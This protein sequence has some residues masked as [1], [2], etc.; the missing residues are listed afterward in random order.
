[1]KLELALD[2]FTPQSAC[3][4][5]ERLQDFIDIVE[6]GTPMLLN[7]GM[8]AVRDMKKAVPGLTLFAD[9]KII[10]GAR[11]E[12]CAAFDAGADIISVVACA[13]DQTIADAVSEA[14]RRGKKVLVDFI[15]VKDLAARAAEISGLGADIF[16]VHMGVDVQKMGQSH[17]PSEILQI[18]QAV[19][20]PEIAV[21]GGISIHNLYA[22]LE[23]GPDI[24][25]VGGGI[26]GQLDPAASA[27]QIR[28]VLD[29]T[30]DRGKNR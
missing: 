24:V 18:K 10:D 30:M 1:M 25:I 15:A 8:A 7:Y 21:A 5:A 19:N 14:S 13:Q 20:G 17:L 22:I 6:V 23:N 2:T 28:A 29:R 12:A 27:G 4:L 16:C 11:I 26:T 3:A 9:T